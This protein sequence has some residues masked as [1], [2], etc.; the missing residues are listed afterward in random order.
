MLADKQQ[1]EQQLQET[2]G[3]LVEA[4]REL[5]R[6]AGGSPRKFAP[7]IV[8]EEALSDAG[9][10]PDTPPARVPGRAAEGDD[11]EAGHIVMAGGGLLAHNSLRQDFDAVMQARFLVA[12]RFTTTAAFPSKPLRVL[13]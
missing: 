2:A 8:A 4:E 1:M 10:G 12:S 13:A 3:E 5:G 6:R 9:F 11:P 7:N